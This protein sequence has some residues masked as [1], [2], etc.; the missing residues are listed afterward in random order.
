M[1]DDRKQTMFAVIVAYTAVV[2]AFLEPERLVRIQAMLT[3]CVPKV[4]VPTFLLAGVALHCCSTLQRKA[5][6]Q[7]PDL[8]SRSSGSTLRRDS[9]TL[10]S[11]KTERASAWT[12]IFEMQIAI[13]RH[14]L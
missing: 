3:G 13:M 6:R 10:T 7:H 1:T 2:S 4:V 8:N 5:G 12:P 14:S 9:P 11:W